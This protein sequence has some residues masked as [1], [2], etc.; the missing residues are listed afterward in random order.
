MVHGP[1]RRGAPKH[2]LALVPVE[3]GGARGRSGGGAGR[4]RE[5]RGRGKQAAVWEEVSVGLSGGDGGGGPFQKEVQ[6]YKLA[7]KRTYPSRVSSKLATGGE[8][9]LFMQNPGELKSD[10]EV[11]VQ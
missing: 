6:L 1:R 3:A 11:D 10:S 2:A 8:K 5:L 9:T 4:A 7:T